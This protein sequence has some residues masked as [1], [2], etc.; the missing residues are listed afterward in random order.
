[1]LSHFYLFE[2]NTKIFYLKIFDKMVDW[3]ILGQAFLLNK[4]SKKFNFKC[5]LMSIHYLYVKFD[6]FWQR[7]WV[8]VTNSNFLIPISLQ[9]HDETGDIKLWIRSSNLS[10]TY[11]R[12]T[13]SGCKDKGL[14]NFEF[15]AKNPIPFPTVKKSL[16]FV[17]INVLCNPPELAYLCKQNGKKNVNLKKKIS[18][19]E[20]Y[21]YI[22]CLRAFQKYNFKIYSFS[23]KKWAILD[24]RLFTALYP[25]LCITKN[26]LN[27]FSWKVAKFHGDSV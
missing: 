9:Y 16:Q 21:F 11:Q 7:N 26:P 24:L 15:V 27:F 19:C 13:S 1:M 2:I 17:H 25:T 8:L 3:L 14:R 23:H 10:L 20:T 6:M 22:H 5:Y 18:K 4:D 12:F